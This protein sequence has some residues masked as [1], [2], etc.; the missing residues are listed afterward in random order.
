MKHNDDNEV[1]IIGGGEKTQ[2]HRLRSIII[3]LLSVVVVAVLVLGFLL[4]GH[5]ET[6]SAASTEQL[7]AVDVMPDK[8]RAPLFMGKYPVSD[9]VIW[10]SKQVKYPQGHELTD[11]RVIVSFVI[12]TDGRVD[13]V[14][15]LNRE[16]GDAFAHEVLRVLGECPRWQPGRLADGTPVAIRYTLP[17][18][19]KKERK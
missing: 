11:A 15:V 19:F 6:P 12:N 4:T 10:V 18:N 17:V 3:V 9:F 2:R 8:A 7:D 5:D 14:C 1:Y 13:S 16:K